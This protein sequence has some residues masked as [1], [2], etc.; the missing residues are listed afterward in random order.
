MKKFNQMERVIDY[1]LS[2]RCQS[3]GFCFYKLDEPNGS[4]SY[5]A[6]SILGLLDVPFQDEKTVTRLQ[7][8]QHSDGSY[9]SIFS[10][11]YSIKGLQL[12]QQKP[13]QD[14]ASYIRKH[15]YHD[16]LDVRKL[17]PE[18]HS[19]FKRLLYVVELYRS[20]EME[21]D[22]VIENNIVDF[23]LSFRNEDQGFGNHASNLT[24]TA[25]AL[26]MLNLLGHPVTEL[27]AVDFIRRCETPVFGFTDI[28]YSSLS[29]ME[30]I[31]AG[32]LASSV[33][34]YRPR[35]HDRC[36]DFILNC[37]NRNGG[38]SRA[39]QAGIATLENTFFAIHARRLLSDLEKTL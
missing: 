37:Q 19:I 21:R 23:I 31:H 17:P 10:A 38:F 9:D 24:E 6:L 33:V 8:M 25:K 4:D 35:Y 20:L 29:Y 27:G 16:A 1:V 36:I 5:Y 28:P 3:G 13:K 2:R 7:N 22:E 32:V 14:P 11:F 15:L 18:I 39:P 30:Y 12:L 34:S 26:V